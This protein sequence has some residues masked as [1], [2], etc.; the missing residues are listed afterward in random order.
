MRSVSLEGKYM[1]DVTRQRTGEFVRKLVEILRAVPEGL[2]AGEAL[3]ILETQFQ[4]TE[5]EKGVFTSGGRRFEHIVR[6]A[7]VDLVKA[8]WLIKQ[9]GQWSVTE[10]GRT[11]F[12]TFA[13]PAQFYREA[14]RLYR[15]WKRDRPAPEPEDEGSS[16][17]EGVERE[18]SVTFERAEEEAWNEIQRYMSIIDPLAFQQLVASLLRA[19]DYHVSW[20]A[21]P[22]K[23][24]GLDIVAWSDP[25]GTKPP[26]I[27]VQVKRV[28]QKVAVDGLR[29]FMALLGDDDVGIFV[30]TA[31][32]T[33]DA[34]DEARVQQKRKVTLI[35]LE[36]L[37]DL[38]VQ[39]YQRLTHEAR[40]Y[41]P[42]TPIH[43]LT[44]KTH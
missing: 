31:G 13:D 29:S 3:S 22:G 28:G 24:G 37:F 21:P 41:L 6:F 4:L 44:P 1:A 8:G 39:Y 14:C 23:D 42:L 20:V 27:K 19:M 16:P 12:D 33:R 17:E 18:V 26:R 7:T 25:L 15:K 35:D 5:Y 11:A 32:F 9:K 34:Y 43:F 40:S 30:A 36:R 2:P 10:A 38:W